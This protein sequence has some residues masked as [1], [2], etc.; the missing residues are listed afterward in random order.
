[1]KIQIKNKSSEEIYELLKLEEN[2]IYLVKIKASINNIEHF[3]TL[4][5]GFKTGSYNTIYSNSYE[6][7]LKLQY[8]YSVSVC[9]LLY[10]KQLQQC[11]CKDEINTKTI[12]VELKKNEC[13]TCGLPIK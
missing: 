3:A 10:S 1:M 4:F 2:S 12:D 6:Y 9:K 8:V 11:N 13:F 5:T 7:P